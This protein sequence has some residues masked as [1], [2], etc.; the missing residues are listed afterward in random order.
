MPRLTRRLRWLTPLVGAGLV[1]GAAAPARSTAFV[2][3]VV[4]GAWTA[5]F[6]EG[7]ADTARCVPASDSE[8]DGFTVCKPVAQAAAVLPDGRV[9]Y[10]NGIES[11]QNAKGP[12]AFS[13][14]PSSRDSQAR[15]LDLRSGTP[16]F[17]EP[18]PDRGGQTNPNIKPGHKWQD[19]P[20]APQAYQGA[21]VT[22]WWAASPDKP[23][24]SPTTRPRHRTTAST[25]TAT[26]S[27][28]T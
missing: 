15:L 11:E 16:Q 14:S 18:T 23:A 8:P 28:P 6:E 19:D 25:T 3:P 4:V 2:D 5:P 7:G 9:F 20:W 27:A 17:T 13:L 1:L 12:S 24:P 22:A 26:C 21:L 10:Y